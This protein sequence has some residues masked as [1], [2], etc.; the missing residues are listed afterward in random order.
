MRIVLNEG[1][2]QLLFEN[3]NQKYI[4]EVKNLIKSGQLENIETAFQMGVWM[5]A[6]GIF[7][8]EKYIKIELNKL[9]IKFTNNV[10]ELQVKHV[11]NNYKNL[12]LSGKQ[13]TAIPKLFNL[14]QSLLHFN[15]ANNKLST[16]DFGGITSLKTLDCSDNVLESLNISTN[17]ALI[18]LNCNNNK[19]TA[20]D[21][22]AN[23]MLDSLYC[24]DN[25]LTTIDLTGNIGL[26]YIH[27]VKN[28]NLRQI[29][30][31]KSRKGLF[32][33]AKDPHTEIIWV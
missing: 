19:L 7:D 10:G 31:P 33:V 15:C 25:L 22:T 26:E 30:I 1:Q 8:V 2:Y 12:N 28:P 14:L 23:T 20:L 16:L 4:E 21:L 17:K 27:C 24:F 9:G 18:V 3:D 11:M 29:L 13:L 6:E 5:K 32:N